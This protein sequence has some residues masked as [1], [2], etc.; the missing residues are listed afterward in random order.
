MLV[1]RFSAMCGE[2]SFQGDTK[3]QRLFLAIMKVATQPQIH[4]DERS[5]GLSTKKSRDYTGG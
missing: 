3:T 2:L 1:V 4:T 5:L